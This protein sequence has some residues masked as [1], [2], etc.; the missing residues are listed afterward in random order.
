MV[1]II[2]KLLLNFVRL[3]G[4]LQSIVINMRYLSFQFND[5]IFSNIKGH[6]SNWNKASIES[7]KFEDHDKIQYYTSFFYLHHL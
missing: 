3:F 7:Q 6:F 1:T 5:T 2:T 4:H